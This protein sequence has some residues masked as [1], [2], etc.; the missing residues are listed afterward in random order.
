[1]VDDDDD[2]GEIAR[3]YSISRGTSY[4]TSQPAGFLDARRADVALCP[5]QFRPV[6][7]E[8]SR[9]SNIKHL[10]TE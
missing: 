7:Y 6:K 1:M 5:M 9:A 8:M 3:L 4:D 2:D 10:V